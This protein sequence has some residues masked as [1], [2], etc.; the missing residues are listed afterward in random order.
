MATNPLRDYDRN[1][2]LAD[3]VDGKWLPQKSVAIRFFEYEASVPGIMVKAQ[4]AL[5]TDENIILTDRSVYW[6]QNSRKIF[7]VPEEQFRES[8]NKRRRLSRRDD[9]SQ[10]PEVAEKIEEVVLAAQELSD[11]SQAIRELTNFASANRRQTLS[12]T[13]NQIAALKDALH[14]WF[15]RVRNFNYRYHKALNIKKEGKTKH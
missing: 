5:G 11:V 6:K 13:E 9:I 7:V 3:L 1:L 10:L 2:F 12:F 14:A 8:R 4:E 15:A